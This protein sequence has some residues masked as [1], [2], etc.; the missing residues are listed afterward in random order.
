MNPYS[1]E[2]LTHSSSAD[3]LIFRAPLGSDL[4]TNTGDRVSIH[5]RVT[6]S[7]STSSFASDSDYHIGANSIFADNTEFI[8]YDQPAVGIKNR[9]SEKVRIDNLLTA[10]GNV[11]TPYRTIQ[12]R[13][14]NSESYTRDINYL[15]VAFSPQRS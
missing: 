13:Y 7:Y 6:G 15:E 1:I 4:N 3:H 8:Y 11:L 14:A 2:G 9:I 5:P 12:Q 10:P